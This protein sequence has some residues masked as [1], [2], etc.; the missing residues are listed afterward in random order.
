MIDDL[1]TLIGLI[2]S[3]VGLVAA[4]AAVIAILFLIII[5]AALDITDRGGGDG[6]PKIGGVKVRKIPNPYKSQV[7]KKVKKFPPNRRR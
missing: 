3:P 7:A 5:V 6:M 1:Q 4:G 2:L